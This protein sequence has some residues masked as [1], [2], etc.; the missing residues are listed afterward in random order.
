MFCVIMK[1]KTLK[2]IIVNDAGSRE[3]AILFDE[4]VVHL[5]TYIDRSKI[6]S[7]G[8]CSLAFDDRSD[9]G[10]I[11]EVWGE[12]TSLKIKC[13]EIDASIIY[14]STIAGLYDY[15]INPDDPMADHIQELIDQQQNKTEQ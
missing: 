5:H 4:R 8:F 10:L 2:Y 1:S 3:A 6:V 7:G 13:R 14:M 12:S 15:H 9:N 11:V